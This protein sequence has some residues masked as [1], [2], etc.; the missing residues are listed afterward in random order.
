M[1][2]TGTLQPTPS[3]LSYSVT[4]VYEAGR[5]PAS[6]VKDL[7]LRPGAKRIPHTYEPDRPCLFYPAGR[8]WRSD[9]KI[10]TSIVPWLSLWL[11]FYEVWLATDEWEGGGI[12]HEPKLD[13]GDVSNS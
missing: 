4:I 8:E 12:S 7:R 2:S 1:R 5:R 6:Y 11:Y 10:A 13:N 3:S 9:M